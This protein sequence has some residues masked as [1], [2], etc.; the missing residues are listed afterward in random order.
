M[1]P[2]VFPQYRCLGNGSYCTH[3]NI[4]TVLFRWSSIFR[5]WKL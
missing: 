4:S 3:Q 5:Y 1:L 2:E